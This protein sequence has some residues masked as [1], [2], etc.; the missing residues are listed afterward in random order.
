MT[1]RSPAAPHCRATLSHTIRQSRIGAKK[2]TQEKG[3]KNGNRNSWGRGRWCHSPKRPKP[4]PPK[5]G[6]Q[7]PSLSACVVFFCQVTRCLAGLAAH[8][9][10]WATSVGNERGEVLTTVVTTS[11]SFDALQPVA[12]GL[13]DRFERAGKERPVVLYTDRDCCVAGT[14]SRLQQLFGA[15]RDLVIK[16]D[17]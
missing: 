8:T 17:T 4:A 10:T 5:T 12:N 16:L 14:Q 3:T 2:N 6:A 1:K 13:M 15:W 11:E 7:G 9:A